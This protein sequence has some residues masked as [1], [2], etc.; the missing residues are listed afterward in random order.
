MQEDVDSIHLLQSYLKGGTTERRG[1]L[2][3]YLDRM[4]AADNPGGIPYLLYR[5]IFS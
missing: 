4:E 5:L 1:T 2:Q 3:M